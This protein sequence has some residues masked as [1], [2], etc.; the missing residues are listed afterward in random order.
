MSAPFGSLAWAALHGGRLT[1]A[2]RITETFHGARGLAV[3]RSARLA[4]RLGVRPRAV[5]MLLA[6]VPIPRGAVVSAAEHALANAEPWVLGHSMRTYLFGS[7]LGVRDGI[8]ADAEV[9][10]VASLLH[11]IGLVHREGAECFAI[12]GAMQARDIVLSANGGDVLAGRVADAISTHLNVRP[13]AT[14]PEARLLRAGAGF[15]VVA[16]R[17]DHLD[18]ASRHEVIAAWTRDG[19]AKPLR[20]VLS[21]EAK[22]HP[23]T[24]MAFLCGGLG[25]LRL[26]E[27]ADRRFVSN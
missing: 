13:V 22:T 16:D 8:R 2:E 17:F 18:A 26:I 1:L 3:D 5:R 19:F 7:M 23:G 15:D 12:R 25:F 27:Q 11:D 21:D 4:R 24:R 9:L 10:L 14:S 6:D 20:A